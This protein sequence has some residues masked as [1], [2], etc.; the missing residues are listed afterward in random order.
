MTGL[1]SHRTERALKPGE[2]LH[3]LHNYSVT[4]LLIWLN[5]ADILL[6]TMNYITI[7]WWLWQ[8]AR[9][10]LN[11][12]S[13]SSSRMNVLRS[14]LI[15]FF[16]LQCF[17]FLGLV[18]L[19]QNL[20]AKVNWPCWHRHHAVWCMGEWRYRRAILTSAL[21]SDEVHATSRCPLH[22]SCV[23]PRAGLDAVNRTVLALTHHP[24]TILTELCKCSTYVS[25]AP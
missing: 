5:V 17:L 7:F 11:T 15:F 18:W 4:F 9:K 13:V 24:I 8:T 3:H 2:S 10:K 16:F 1:C 14:D 6:S 12:L 19:F 25:H 21:L 23:G 20:S 22:R